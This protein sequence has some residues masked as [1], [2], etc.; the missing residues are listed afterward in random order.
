[1]RLGVELLDRVELLARAD[2]P[3]RGAGD[4]LD[5]E[6]RPAARVGV[7]LAE[8]DAVDRE[9][10]VEGLGAGDG[11]LPRHRINDKEDLVRLERGVHAVQFA[12]QLVVDVQTPGG[13]EDEDVD[14]FLT[15]GLERV[16]ADLHRHA[17][18]LAVRVALVG[19]GVEVNR[20][21]A[22]HAIG[23]LGDDLKLLDSRG[24][25]EVG[26]AEHDAPALFLE[27]GRQFAAGGRFARALQP[28]HHDDG[29]A[30]RDLEDA[31]VLRLAAQE[32]HELLVDD[33]DHLLPGLEALGHLAPDGLLHHPVTERLDDVVLHVGFEQR[34][35]D[36]GHRLA[37]VGLTDLGLA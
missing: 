32:C 15:R 23:L 34:G 25:L 18:G 3:D 37:D 12:H 8:D 29:G 16:L 9:L 10:L 21:T 28:A 27:E 36:L 20:R 2:E 19:L 4:F 14:V 31:R 11:V 30:G 24:A 22:R 26:G 1:M 13:V 6:R 5:T 17:H 35:L 33:A 7:E